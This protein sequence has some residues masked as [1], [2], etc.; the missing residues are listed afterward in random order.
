MTT[1]SF[2]PSPA[3]AGAQYQADILD[4]LDLSP[5]IRRHWA[6]AFAG[7]AVTTEA[8]ECRA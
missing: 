1:H 6:P 4:R 3:K 7:E 2:S 5:K 8:Q